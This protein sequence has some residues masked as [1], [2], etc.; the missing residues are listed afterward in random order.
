MSEHGDAQ[1][2][3]LYTFMTKPKFIYIL[4]FMC[5]IMSEL[6]KLTKIFQSDNFNYAKVNDLLNQGLT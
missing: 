5:D 4:Y 1:V 2:Q 6:N 3:G